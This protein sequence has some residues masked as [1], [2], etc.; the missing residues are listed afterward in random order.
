MLLNEKLKLSI[1]EEQ[2]Y[3]FQ[4]TRFPLAKW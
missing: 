2:Y 3:V 1:A 4:N